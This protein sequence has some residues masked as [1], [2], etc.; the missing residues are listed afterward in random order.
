MKSFEYLRI[1]L[2]EV[3]Q[4]ELEYAD[5]IATREDYI[6]HAFGAS[7]DFSHQG[8]QF[9]YEH[10]A[11][12]DGYVAGFIANRTVKGLR[13]GQ[14]EDYKL[15]EAEDWK[16][17]G[18]LIDSTEHPDGQKIAFEHGMIRE[19]ENFFASLAKAINASHRTAK[20]EMQIGTIGRR[21][22]YIEAAKQHKGKITKL[23]FRILAKNMDYNIDKSVKDALD[24]FDELDGRH[25]DH[26]TISSG[27]GLNA[28][29]DLADSMATYAAES[30]GS[31]KAYDK[32]DGI[33]YDSKKDVTRVPVDT[34]IEVDKDS[35]KSILALLIEKLFERRDKSDNE[36]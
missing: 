29:S 35:D 13:H 9:I 15:Y 26:T 2:S 24:I 34:E 22:K 19:S 7:F 18:V 21:Q 28:D 14:D 4:L 16:T 11:T 5:D 10:V 23:S 31:V 33:I 8:K 32:D 25:T 20:W 6:K 36:S 1:N 17:H 12:I 30:G 27:K 3:K